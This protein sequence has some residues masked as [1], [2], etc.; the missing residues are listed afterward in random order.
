MHGQGTYETALNRLEGA[1]GILRSLPP[2]RLHGAHVLDLGCGT[3]NMLL[4]AR[5]AGAK[6]AFGI[7]LNLA[8]F[9][10]N[11]L[12]E[13]GERQ[14]I[15]VDAISM[16]EANFCDYS[17]GKQFG[18]ITCFDVL[19]H[20]VEPD[21]FLENMRRHLSPGGMAIIDI[22]PFYY[23]Q[24]GH[25]MF[26]H[27]S[28]EELPWVHLYHDFQQR[29]EANP[30]DNW[31]WVRFQELN[32]MTVSKLRALVQKLGFEINTEH[33]CETGRD[34]VEMYRDRIDMKQVPAEEDLFLEW[35]RLDLTV[36]A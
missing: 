5:E 31:T 30:I 12:D 20:V 33:G 25:H 11:F 17:A 8:E 7:D 4:A 9:G 2:D 34:V 13:L 24:V 19:E 35:R 22:S 15:P 16:V 3:G 18:L 26:S 28:R 29:I 27:F 36:P 32:R 23:S 21:R 1:R 10:H 6:T 14:K